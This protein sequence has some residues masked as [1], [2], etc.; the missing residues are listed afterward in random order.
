MKQKWRLIE[1]GTYDA[2]T[3]MAIDEALALTVKKTNVSIIR[4]GYR[5]QEP[6]AVSFGINQNS[7]DVDINYCKQNKLDIVR[8]STGGQALFHSP[9]DFTYCVIMNPEGN[10]KN[11]M[12]SYYE[13]CSWIIASFSELGIKARYDS[14]SSILAE[15]KK[16]CGNA[17]TRVLGPI[18]QHGSIFY[19]LNPET[20]EKIFKTKKEE[21]TEKATCIKDF[22]NISQEEVYDAFKEGF[23]KNKDFFVD[24]LNEEEME[25]VNKLLKNKYKTDQWNF[26]YNKPIKG[27]CHVQWENI[28]LK[29]LL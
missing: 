18:L 3:N 26:N 8:R 28:T 29:T 14:S 4:L 9:E 22:R 23:L 21:I 25:R 20:M 19:S 12:D 15:N 2:Y 5:W 10:F 17:Q 13:I 16:I 11:F 7:D 27:S 24:D 6:G 1:K